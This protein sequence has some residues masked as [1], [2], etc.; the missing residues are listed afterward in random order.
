[1]RATQHYRGLLYASKT[2]ELANSGGREFFDTRKNRHPESV[3]RTQLAQGMFVTERAAAEPEPRTHH[4]VRRRQAA[5]K[6]FGNEHFRCH[7][8]Y[9][10]VEWHDQSGVYA[11]FGR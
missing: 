8:G 5:Y 2:Q 10:R 4:H 6:Y 1:M 7:L 9:F 11:E 3:Q